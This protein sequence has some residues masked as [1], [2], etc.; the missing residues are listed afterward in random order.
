[1]S[2]RFLGLLQVTRVMRARVS[3]TA[4]KMPSILSQ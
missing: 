1:M 2:P 3:S 4:R